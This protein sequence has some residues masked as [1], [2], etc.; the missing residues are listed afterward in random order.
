[1]IPNSLLLLGLLCWFLVLT[2]N[3]PSSILCQGISLESSG[4]K[5]RWC[6]I[7][8]CLQSDLYF[9]LSE[10][11]VISGC[12]SWRTRKVISIV[13]MLPLC[14]C[15]HTGWRTKWSSIWSVNKIFISVTVLETNIQKERPL[16]GELSSVNQVL[17]MISIMSG[18]ST[19]HILSYLVAGLNDQCSQF[20]YYLRLL[21]RNLLLKESA[22][23]SWV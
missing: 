16:H 23:A 12:F 14:I 7:V 17:N 3:L 19:A 20:H 2:V 4:N 11:F 1:M 10:Y 5:T 21:Q 18:N 15:D 9:T 6:P 13:V 22:K 8:K